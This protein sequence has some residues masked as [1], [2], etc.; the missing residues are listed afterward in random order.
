M[1]TLTKEQALL[2]W[3]VVYGKGLFRSIEWD[4]L[5]EVLRDEH[6]SLFTLKEIEE[7]SGDECSSKEAVESALRRSTQAVLHAFYQSLQ[8]TRD[9]G[10]GSQH[11]SIAEEIEI[12]SECDYYCIY[13]QIFH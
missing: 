13:L 10:R 7:L 3:F 9:C 2:I 6:S 8:D 1:L 5:C 4:S 11:A 12:L